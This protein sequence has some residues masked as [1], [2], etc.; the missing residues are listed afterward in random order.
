MST[1]IKL[2]RVTNGTGEILG[3][4][5]PLKFE[6]NCNQWVQTSNK[7]CFDSTLRLIGNLKTEKR[8]CKK[9][10]DYSKPIHSS[11][12]IS[13]N[14]PKESLFSVEEYEVFKISPRK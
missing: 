4:Y 11:E 7:F 9:I 10:A 13:P 6:K 8:C 5:N 2:L 12:F 1:I 14:I 3:G